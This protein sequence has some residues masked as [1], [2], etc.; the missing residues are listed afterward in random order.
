MSPTR[1]V[2]LVVATYNVHDCVGRDGHRDAARVAGV[3]R[4]LGADVVALQEVSHEALA[5]LAAES[6]FEAIAAPTLRDGRGE[7]GNALLTRMSV[8]HVE[9]VDISVPGREP[10]GALE[11]ELETPAGRLRVIATHLGLRAP[12]RT[13]QV[14]RLLARLP[15]SGAVA[16]LGDVNEWRPRARSLR[17]LSAGLGPTRAVRSF[18]AWRPLFALDRI[19]ARAPARLERLGAHASS[20]ARM[21]SDHLPVRAELRLTAFSSAL[22]G[23]PPR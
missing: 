16:L 12:E 1:T 21:A 19:F 8:G 22:R 5:R 2:P 11:V 9:R 4:E 18:P 13:R 10:R 20:A 6:G 23:A 17:R 14:E 15:E 3:I 7:Y